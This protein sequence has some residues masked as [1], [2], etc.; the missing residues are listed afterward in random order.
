[1][2]RALQ[3]SCHDVHE[4]AVAEVIKI[5]LF[6]IFYLA[7]ADK[8]TLCSQRSSTIF[9][10][11]IKTI[12]ESMPLEKSRAATVKSDVVMRNPFLA[13][14]PCN[15]PANFRM[16]VRPIFPSQRLACR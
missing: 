1:M 2:H 10:L 11:K 12:L 13:R 8:P 5:N 15:A 9:F 7:A 14:L 3:G 16:S 6:L 4:L